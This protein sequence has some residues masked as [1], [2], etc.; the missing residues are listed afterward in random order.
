M[1]RHSLITV[2]E[3]RKL[4]GKSAEDLKDHQVQETIALLT[5]LAGNYLHKK[6]SKN[7]VGV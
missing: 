2:K 1:K 5:V 3:A 4:L 6:G 7:I